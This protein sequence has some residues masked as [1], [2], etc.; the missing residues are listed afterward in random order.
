VSVASDLYARALA[1]SADL[2]PHADVL[3]DTV[4]ELGAQRVIE[5]GV[6]DGY[7]TGALLYG[8]EQ[9]GGALWSVDINP[10]PLSS[11]PRWTFVYG[12]DTDK[13]ILAQLPTEVDLVFIDTS[14][15][16]AHTLR[17]LELYVP[18]VRPGGRVLLHDTENEDPAAHGE[19]I[20]MQ[21]P[22]PVKRAVEDY[23]AEHALPWK[24]DDRLWG[25]G[26]IYL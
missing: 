14:H 15:A 20:G 13:A 4:V 24:N 5:L 18:R 2:G 10:P 12:D 16:W 25:L 23:C 17:E 11:L 3:A 7:S 6:R 1:E 9:T 26:A 21:P 19:P 8:L 22:F